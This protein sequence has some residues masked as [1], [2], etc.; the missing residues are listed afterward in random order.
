VV[1]PPLDVRWWNHPKKT[2]KTLRLFESMLNLV[3]KFK[4]TIFL[5]KKYKKNSNI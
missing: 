4:I 3:K 2:S 5:L 1:E